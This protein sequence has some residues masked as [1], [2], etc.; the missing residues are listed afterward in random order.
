TSTA[1]LHIIRTDPLLRMLLL[2]LGVFVTLGSMVNVV[3]VF[4]IRGTLHAS[5]TWYGISGAALAV[6]MLGGAL[7]GGRLR[8]ERIQ[9]RALVAAAVALAGTLAAIAAV[10]SVYWLLPVAAALGAANGVLNV[11]LGAMVMGRAPQ[12]VRGR[13][14]AAVSATSSAAQ[15]GAYL[16]GGVLATVLTPRTI[17]LLAGALGLLAPVLLGRAVVRAAST[18]REAA[19][20][21]VTTAQG[22]AA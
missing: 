3:E 14:A 10:P 7:A 8:G 21:A 9:A 6:G 19:D 2:L 13:V 20:W 12:T 1:G 5:A 17:F 18:H 11:A 22:A 16:V 4:L 15:I